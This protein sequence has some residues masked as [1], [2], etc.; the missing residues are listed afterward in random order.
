M[1]KGK[2]AGAR[3]G[4]QLNIF[5]DSLASKTRIGVVVVLNLISSVPKMLIQN[6]FSSVYATYPHKVSLNKWQSELL[7]WKI[8]AE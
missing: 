7:K 3:D 8:G 1:S 5:L 4:W 2:V 6:W